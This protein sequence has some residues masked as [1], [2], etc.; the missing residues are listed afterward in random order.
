MNISKRKIALALATSMALS[1]LQVFAND[2]KDIQEHWAK[3]TIYSFKEQGFI[4]RY[5]EENFLPNREITR[6][7]LITMLNR[8]MGLDGHAEVSFSD[9]P[10]GSELYEELSVAVAN[11]YIAGFSDGSFRPD[12]PVSRGEICVFLERLN[13]IPKQGNTSKKIKDMDKV[14]QWAKNS[15]QA[16]ANANL[17]RG[18][19][20]GNFA[21]SKNLTRAETIA[22]L[23]NSKNIENIDSHALIIRKES[24]IPKNRIIKKNVI[25]SEEI[26]DK[27]LLL[28][29]LT[30]Q[31]DLILRGDDSSPIKIRNTKVLGEVQINRK[32]AQVIFSGE[33]SA[34]QIRV[35]AESVIGAEDLKN[36]LSKVVVSKQFVGQRVEVS[37]PTKDLQVYKETNIYVKENIAQMVVFLTD[38]PIHLMVDE[39]KSVG[40]IA[41]DEARHK[42]A[43]EK[44]TPASSSDKKKETPA[45]GG[46]G[47]GGGGG[48]Y[49]AAPS[50]PIQK[51]PE[52]PK[53]ETPSA[54][55]KEGLPSPQKEKTT[56]NKP[57]GSSDSSAAPIQEQNGNTEQQPPAPPKE[58]QPPKDESGAEPALPPTPPSDNEGGKQA[59]Q[60]LSNPNEES[61]EG[62]KNPPSAPENSQT[63]PGSSSQD[64][65]RDGQPTDP[66]AVSEN[67]PKPNQPSTDSGSS[68][69]AD[70]STDQTP[71]SPPA[72]E[73]TPEELERE[74]REAEQKKEEE[75]KQKAASIKLDLESRGNPVEQ[76]TDRDGNIRTILWTQG[77]T[78]PTM[79]EDFEYK[80]VAPGYEE[81]QAPYK[82]GNNWYDTNKVAGTQR[83][84]YLCFAS[85]AANMM[86]WWYLQNQDNIAEYIKIGG[87][88]K[89]I[90]GENETKNEHYRSV[91]NAEDF[92]DSHKSPSD[93]AWMKRFIDYFGHL[94]KGFNSDLLADLMING[95][96]PTEDGAPH[97]K[98]KDFRK[99]KFDNRGG[100]FYP[101]FGD[102]PLTEKF[103][104]GDYSSFGQSIKAGLMDGKIIGL[105]HLTSSKGT[106][107]IITLWG[108]E[109]D[110]DGNIT[111]VF[112][113]DSDDTD[114]GNV[115]MRRYNVL[116][117]GNKPYLSTRVD[118]NGGAGIE[119]IQTLSTGEKL[120]EEYFRKQNS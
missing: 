11:G 67:S 60:N 25:I 31:G 18:Y 52:I 43:I 61:Q 92:I 83:D 98:E 34:R 16:A 35:F 24:D 96:K 59:P 105:E 119:Y 51:E 49:T 117:I 113:T 10:I 87:Q 79:A 95:Y 3:E 89:N 103:F 109:Y 68:Q 40:K 81:Y 107:H 55:P 12:E 116:K 29:G 23:S 45:S 72:S 74:K 28:D 75:S 44:L 62:D 65:S 63:A 118:R 38:K 115:A 5:K 19:E 90:A 26:K 106:T 91:L 56:P 73:K 77:I 120:W 57:E 88:D 50:A 46:G 70:A 9:V 99:F 110:L 97:A 22:I 108:A 71:N 47:G 86:H 27:N 33:S 1:N 100:L 54:Q 101:V 8:S 6:A 30:I 42:V 39:N 93:S 66:P 37:A 13:K 102:E 104:S 15:V 7:E 111:A 84:D 48:G 2:Y 80:I 69:N 53:V 17:I 76:Y 78:P 85:V 112:I 114:Y 58:S 36:E 21:L 14:P 41:T 82:A 64:E 94:T 4:E 32:N 20:N